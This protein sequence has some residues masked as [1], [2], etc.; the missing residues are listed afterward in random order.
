MI[1]ILEIL[2]LADVTRDPTTGAMTQVNNL[3]LINLVLVYGGPTTEKNCALRVVKLQLICSCI[4]FLIRYG[5]ATII[6]SP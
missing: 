4:G 6:F 3:T 2:K 5:L 1:R